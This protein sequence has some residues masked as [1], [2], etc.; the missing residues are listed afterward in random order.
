MNRLLLA[1]VIALIPSSVFA[2]TPGTAVV[3]P[4]LAT[5]KGHEV[6]V[7]LGGYDYVEPG[8]LRISI[9]GAKFAAEYTGTFSLNQRQHWFARA[10][11]RTAMGRTTYDGWCAPW[12]IVPESASPNGYALDLGDFSPCSEGGGKDWY[13]EGRALVGK[14]FVGQRWAW[15]PES[16]LGVRHLSNGFA[17]LAGF[18][19]E[20]YLYLPV[21]LTVR[22]AISSR[23]VLS[24]NLEYDRLL[25]GWQ[26]TR[27]SLLG[28]GDV[29]ATS[30]APAFTLDGFDDISFDQHGGSALRASAK[31]QVNKN[32]SVEPYYV[33]WNVDDSA[34]N[35]GSITYTVNGI[36][37]TEQLGFLEPVNFTNEFGVKFGFR[38]F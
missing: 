34:V 2:Q 12:L 38:F 31:Y 4:I 14:D 33:R 8:D 21:G 19:T 30:T 24:F 35:L 18:R 11:A 17:G 32:W 20:K 28:S 25:R 1:S 36:T 5:P 23:S 16:G 15:S 10:T 9:H 26:T 13:L 7:G 29:P 37:A 6:G 22:T 27:N 3:V